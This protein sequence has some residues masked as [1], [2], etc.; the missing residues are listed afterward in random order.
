[1][2]SLKVE[3]ENESL[4]TITLQTFFRL[5]NKRAGMTGTADTVAVEF[6]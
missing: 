2:V 1:M 3:R 4:A 5:Y 6:K